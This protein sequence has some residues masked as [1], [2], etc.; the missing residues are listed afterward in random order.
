MSH[1]RCR[2]PPPSPSKAA[3]ISERKLKAFG[4]AINRKYCDTWR[5]LLERFENETKGSLRQ[6]AP[7]GC[8]SE[9]PDIRQE[10]VS[11]MSADW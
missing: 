2:A 3:D 10:R 11:G 5:W 8:R 9:Q 7:L 4:G 1:M 6:W